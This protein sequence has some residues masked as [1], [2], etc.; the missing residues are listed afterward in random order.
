MLLNTL[1]YLFYLEVSRKAVPL[2][3]VFHSI[4]F[5]V[6]KGWSTAVLL[7]LCP[8]VSA[9]L[10]TSMMFQ[11]PPKERTNHRYPQGIH[12]KEDFLYNIPFGRYKRHQQQYDNCVWQIQDSHLFPKILEVPSASEV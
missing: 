10:K 9:A 3:C 1:F 6:N 11:P 8:Y 4:R 7:F 5:K 12:Q 2:H